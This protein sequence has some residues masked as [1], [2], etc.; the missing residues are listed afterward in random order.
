M[1]AGYKEAS[2][3]VFYRG[4]G[5]NF[6]FS[7]KSWRRNSGDRGVTQSTTCLPCPRLPYLFVITS[8]EKRYF[9][10]RRAPQIMPGC[11][12]RFRA[13]GK[14]QITRKRETAP[15]D[16]PRRRTRN[17]SK[18]FVIQSST[19]TM[20]GP[21]R[22]R[23]ASPWRCDQSSSSACHFMERRTKIHFAHSWRRGKAAARCVFRPWGG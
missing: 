15:S 7:L 14:N 2:K 16:A 9:P 4:W 13:S 11:P 1:P 17:C 18:L 19:A 21:S 12:T 6:G 10:A 20:S 8:Q 22:K 5:R 23:P 3:I